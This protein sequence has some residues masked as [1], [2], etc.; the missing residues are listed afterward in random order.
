MAK[1]NNGSAGFLDYCSVYFLYIYMSYNLYVTKKRYWFDEE[2][3][4]SISL[5]SFEKACEAH[6][7]L[8][9]LS[10][11]QG[12]MDVV[13][14]EP[15]RPAEKWHLKYA[16]GSVKADMRVVPKEVCVVL[17]E[18]AEK[19]HAKVQGEEGEVYSS[20][21]LPTFMSIDELVQKE[22]EEAA[23]YTAEQKTAQRKK[24][25]KSLITVPLKVFFLF[26]LA[27]TVIGIIFIPRL[28]KNWFGSNKSSS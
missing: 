19:L 26:A 17:L 13:Y 12:V 4:K 5:K 3:S 27:S 7:A 20:K 25:L 24:L 6:P 10:K 16:H 8:T 1:S 18:L 28:V 22:K 23:R 21:D 14:I 2:D 11:K 15:S 9:I